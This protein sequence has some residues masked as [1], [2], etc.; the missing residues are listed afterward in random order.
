MKLSKFDYIM[1][2]TIGI[3]LI[4][5][6]SFN[7]AFKIFGDNSTK[8]ESN[9]KVTSAGNPE[10]IL[11]EDTNIVLKLQNSSNEINIKNVS[12]KEVKNFLAGDITLTK[13]KE[14]YERKD[15]KFFQEGNKEIIFTKETKFIPQKYYIGATDKEFVAIFKCDNEGNLYIEDPDNDI[16]NRTLEMLPQQY[17][18]HLQS[19]ELQFNTKEEAQDELMAI[20]S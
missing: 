6:I 14:Y 13:V 17:Q 7:V 10:R 18:S 19:F 9:S 20:C 11:T 15:Y 2:Y 16:S 3:L 5:T 12:L 4:F 1:I 8:Y